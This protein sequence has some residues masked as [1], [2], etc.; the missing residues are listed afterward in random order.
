MAHIQSLH[1]CIDYKIQLISISILP[2]PIWWCEDWIF[3]V[4]NKNPVLTPPNLHWH[5]WYGYQLNPIPNP[6]VQGLYPRSLTLSVNVQGKLIFQN[7]VI[8]AHNQSLHLRIG[9]RIQ[10]IPISMR[11]VQIWRCEDWIFV[12]NTKCSDCAQTVHAPA[13]MSIYIIYVH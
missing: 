7:K 3:M 12:A 6:E 5:H 13:N 1:L 2:V 11:L 8:M 9:N 10:M 4:W